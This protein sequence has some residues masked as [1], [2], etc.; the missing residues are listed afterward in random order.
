MKHPVQET[1]MNLSHH[2]RTRR[3]PV[4]LVASCDQQFVFPFCCLYNDIYVA[5]ER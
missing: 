3:P 1:E 5:S 2:L 4:P